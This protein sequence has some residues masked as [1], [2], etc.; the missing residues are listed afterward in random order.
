MNLW[1]TIC[2]FSC[3]SSTMTVHAS[4]TERKALRFSV[5][6]HRLQHQ[7]QKS[8]QSAMLTRLWRWIFDFKSWALKT[9]FYVLEFCNW[10]QRKRR[11]MSNKLSKG[12]LLVLGRHVLYK[13]LRCN[14][15]SFELFG[16][17][18]MRWGTRQNCC[19]GLWADVHVL[20]FVY[21]FA[22]FLRC[23]TG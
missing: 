11:S 6:R 21:S 14:R 12:I 9:T 15:T 4:P 8:Q 1:M 17:C 16:V 20:V 23:T 10:W 22:N 3:S 2:L 19:D 13:I 18:E 5:Y 7:T